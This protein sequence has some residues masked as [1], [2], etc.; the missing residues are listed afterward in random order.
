M[1]VKELE[2]TEKPDFEKQEILER[3]K[4]KVSDENSGDKDSKLES[5]I[6]VCGKTLDL[7]LS[8][9]DQ[10][11]VEELYIY[12]NELNLIPR[13]VGRL[14]S[15]KTLKFFSNEVNLFP[16]EIRNLID[17]EFLQVKVAA[18]GVNGLELSKLRNLKELELSRV[19]QRSSAFPILNDISGLKCL[20]R[21]SV[22][23]FSIR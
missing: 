13:A 18:L 8:N 22:C 15:L 14:K 11:L 16:V 20:K 1:Q 19:P 17:L 21:L 4:P 9:G 3:I 7:P 10:R 5:V 6:D 23:H 2:K 12:K